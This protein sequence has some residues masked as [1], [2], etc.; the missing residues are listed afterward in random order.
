MPKKRKRRVAPEKEDPRKAMLK[1]ILWGSF[2]SV[3]AFFVLIFILSVVVMKAGMSDSMQ[4]LLTMTS[5]LLA[6]FVGAFFSLRKTREKGM[7]SGL[8]TALPAVAVACVVLLAV[9]GTLGL[10]TVVMALLMM[11]GGALGGIAAVN[12]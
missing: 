11:L 3:A 2:Y 10:R 9:F 12:R 7:V 4:T 1:R 5:S 6:V 8:L